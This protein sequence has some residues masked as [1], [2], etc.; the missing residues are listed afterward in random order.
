MFYK[1]FTQDVERGVL[2]GNVGGTRGQFKWDTVINRL[3]TNHAYLK[4]IY[5][6]PGTL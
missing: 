1:E 4:M 6:F 5:G 3:S 2:Q